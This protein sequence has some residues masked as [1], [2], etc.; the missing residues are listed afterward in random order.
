[1]ADV[2]IDALLSEQRV[3]APD[4]A[5]TAQA[6]AGPGFYD[7]DPDEFWTREG[8]ERVSW[9]RPFDAL[10][11]WQPPYARWYLGG[12]LNVCYNCVDRHVEAGR[13]DKVAYHWEGEPGG[14]RRDITYAD[15]QREVVP[16]RQR[17]QVPRRAQGHPGR[18][19][20]SA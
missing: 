2:N 17:P 6:N 19:S 20:T 5:F 7:Q 12:S 15:L 13:G 10:K 18:P 16:L 14:E 4:P 8:R 11:E 1:M 9:F 3:F